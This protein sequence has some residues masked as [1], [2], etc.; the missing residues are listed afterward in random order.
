[1]VSYH[2]I[3]EGNMLYDY[4]FYYH[5]CR[6]GTWRM[7]RR[8]WAWRAGRVIPGILN[9][10]G[11]GMEMPNFFLRSGARAWALCT[12]QRLWKDFSCPPLPGERQEKEAEWLPAAP[13]HVL[14]LNETWSSVSVKKYSPCT[15]HFLG[16]NRRE[17]NDKKRSHELDYNEVLLM[18][19]LVREEFRTVF[20]LALQT[21]R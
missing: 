4:Y 16:N 8:L 15:D 17:M 21:Q 20:S 6:A 19:V 7:N 14:W 9:F 5:Y 1:M 11:R 13:K 12:S 3:E 2:R 10:K 18:L